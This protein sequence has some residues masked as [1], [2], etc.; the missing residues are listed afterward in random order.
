MCSSCV[1]QLTLFHQ[2]DHLRRARRP[3]Y[4]LRIAD[5]NCHAGIASLPR[6]LEYRRQPIHRLLW[7][8]RILLH[9]T[10]IIPSRRPLYGLHFA[11]LSLCR[12]GKPQTVRII[13][14]ELCHAVACVTWTARSI[15]S[16]PAVIKLR[17]KIRCNR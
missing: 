7:T 17:H 6:A 3:F 12:N 4:S 16:S 10:V 9:A 8:V 2:S 15:S 5:G 11:R 1:V 13:L 14:M